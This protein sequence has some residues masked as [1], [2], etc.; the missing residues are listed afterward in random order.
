MLQEIIRPE[1]IPPNE[2][3]QVT[4]SSLVL[5]IFKYILVLFR[6]FFL[7]PFIKQTSQSAEPLLVLSVTKN[8]VTSTYIS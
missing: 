1:F 3:A 8:Y 2:L 6:E 5:F 4:L 7:C